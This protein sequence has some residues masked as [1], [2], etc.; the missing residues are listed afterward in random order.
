MV[1]LDWLAA[2]LATA[3]LA[4]AVPNAPPIVP[5]AYIVEYQDDQDSAAFVEALPGDASL[6]KDLRFQLFKGASIQFPDAETAEDMAAT[7]AKMSI[8]KRVYPV[9]R[10]A[11]PNYTVH[12]TG[13]AA[14]N[15]VLSKRQDG[16]N[17]TFSPHLMTQV[18]KFRDA[19][20]TG[21]GL[22]I[23]IVDTGTDYLHPALGGCFGP[24]CLVSYGADLVGDSFNGKN[25]PMPDSDPMDN[26]NGHGTHVA[27]IIAA[28]A[29]K[30]PYGILGA[31]QGVTLG[32]F[33]V[34]GCS[35]DVS[36]DILIAAYNMAY[37]AGS[38]IITASIGGASGWSE[39]PWAT[40]V[41]RIVAKGVP[42]VVSAGNDGSDGIF[43]ASTAANGKAVTAIASVDNTVSPS[44]LSNATYTVNGGALASFGFTAGDP[45]AWANVSLPLWAVSFNTTD[46]ANGCDPYPASTP[47]L[48]GYVVLVRRG[49][50]TFVQKASNAA[51]KGAKYVI[52]YNNI[53]GSNGVTAQVA[54]I[55]GVAMVT[56]NTGATWIKALAAGSN[57]T[58]NMID[59][60]TGPMFLTNFPNTDTPGFLSTY[61]S[62]GPTFEVDVKPQFST[63]GGM[64][65]STYP[66]ALG[67]YGVLSG[68]SM[69]CPLA[70]AIYALII[71]VRKTKDP[72]TLENLIS[73]TA[74][75][76]VFQ[77][78][79]NSYPILA[80]VPQQGGG[81]VQAWDAAHA[82]TILSV[83]SLSFNDTDHFKAV[84][85]FDIQNTGKTDVS[86][87]LG[88]IGAATA[89]T[90][91]T[92]A[93][94]TPDTFPN[95]LDDS[96]A[97]L[98]FG[99]SGSVAVAAGQTKT[100]QVTVVP[101][102][103]LDAKRLPV[104]SG[105][106]TINGSDGSAF[107]LPYLGVAGSMHGAVV[108]DKSQTL[109]SHSFDSKSAPVA[110]NLT[111][112]LP[113]PG[114][115]NDTAYRNKTDQPKLVVTLAMGSAL[116]R[117]DLVAIGNGTVTNATTILGT[118]TLGSAD[119]FPSYW[120]TRG[121]FEYTFDGKLADGT[122]VPPGL[123]KFAVKAL[124]IFGNPELASE[125]DAT[126]SVPFRVRYTSL[127]KRSLIRGMA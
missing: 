69:A 54:G 81:L 66:R 127:P 101:P 82:T 28:Q 71:S 116:V 25:T 24:G 9:K 20:I 14:V 94:I 56:A 8:V 98:S 33:R 120:N 117:A 11:I 75:P 67:S 12:S 2:L 17:D 65:L 38:D 106:I 49:T 88:H 70:A 89:Y 62:W 5:G 59:P 109:L 19:G 104:Y 108:L 23:G 110:A 1:R 53:G 91:A 63:P 126:E 57:I 36:N 48:A 97:T 121:P 3:S 103:G 47:N 61:T 15:S 125:Y 22:K 90:F 73:A 7:V 44:L 13:N 52:Y 124:R 72:K 45:D 99:S 6:R 76:N 10:Y 100:V 84:H 119:E 77:D 4:R 105:Y 74:H 34:F 37:E 102:A 40:V 39:D 21:T 85:S 107:S 123:Y 60:E 30:N 35:G 79:R 113:P 78:G 118:T 111:F 51:A 64:I 122:F 50:C 46:P 96:I 58:V 42:C 83:S 87:S 95:E 41:S 55:K 43:Y 16:A 27:G 80:P 31:A 93:D 18:N 114:Y 32:S 29:G 115:A 68:T 86:F 92:T 26:C 112:T